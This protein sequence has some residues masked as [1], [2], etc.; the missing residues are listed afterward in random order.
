MDG[1]KK[2]ST[3][4]PKTEFDSNPE[5]NAVFQQQKTLT[6][7]FAKKEELY[8]PREETRQEE[9]DELKFQKGQLLRKILW[10]FLIIA[11]LLLISFAI[12]FFSKTYIT[13]KKMNGSSRQTTLSQDMK[14]LF[15]PIMPSSDEHTLKGE[16][17]GRINILLLG[18]AGENK[19]GGNL[20]DTV[21]IMSI[22]TKNKKVAL[23][24]LPRDLYVQIPDSNSFTKINSLYKIGLA[25]QKG[26]D[27]I[28]QA[29]E[30]VTGISIDYY[31][32]V[33]YNAFAKIIDDINGINVMVERDIYDPTYPGPNYSYELFSLKK[34]AHLLGG[35]TALKYVR[36]RHDDPEG[37]FGRAK[38]QQQVIQA[39]KS[40]L[41][42]MQTLFN[43]VALNNVLNT[44]GSNIKTDMSFD[45]IEQFIKLSKVVDTQNITNVV[46]D[47][48]KPDS[49]LKVS[50]I[51]LG[52]D[53]AFILIPRVGSYS[54]IQDL[55]KNIFDQ[56][57]LKKRQSLITQEAASIEI[58]NQ[59]T[60]KELA[61]KI[62]KLLTEKLGL[63]NVQIVSS[64]SIEI[65]D[66]TIIN[67]GSDS[68]KI[69]TLDELIKKL[70]A[71][72]N[73]AKTESTSDFTITLGND[74][75]DLYKY[76]EDT[77]EELNNNSDNQEN[78]DFTKGIN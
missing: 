17:K 33:D 41:F 1:I 10:T 18:A 14:S 72:F 59:S 26:T 42:S 23:L 22:D 60:D 48:W 9:K 58:I 28:K 76:E 46:V 50:H 25:Q 2:K 8:I 4:T 68:E 65:T 13:T 19:P 34:G 16:D 75:I 12:F 31:L 73:S 30:K 63:K 43:V 3:L 6:A 54:E 15:A 57:E 29:V 27:L 11:L 39:I 55:A 49:L 20:T 62:R 36:E 52:D 44:L 67:S 71:S 78:F 47:A 40:R 56:T 7:Y 77:M 45:D 53:R 21:M 74:L 64:N 66:K 51:T 5:L 61:N 35:D 32:T 24:S 69:F 37:D 70:P 38:R